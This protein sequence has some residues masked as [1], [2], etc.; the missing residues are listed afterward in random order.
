MALFIPGVPCAICKQPVA[1]GDQTLFPPFTGNQADPVYKFSDGV[2][3]EK[4]YCEAPEWEAVESVLAR[5]DEMRRNKVC[6]ICHQPILHSD[7]YFAL[8]LLSDDPTNAL[9]LWNFTWFH[10][11]CLPKWA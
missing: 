7:E 10:R 6:V 5:L 4:C 11:S 1:A 8:T 9:S 3:H 2:A